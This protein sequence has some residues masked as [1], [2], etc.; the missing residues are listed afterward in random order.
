[1]SRGLHASAAND[2]RILAADPIEGICK[3]ILTQRR[4]ELVALDKTPKPEDLIKMIPEY[5][6]LIVRRYVAHLLCMVAVA[7]NCS[8][9]HCCMLLRTANHNTNRQSHVPMFYQLYE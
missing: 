7:A 2:A 1:L 4:H 5:D 8:A 9:S 6:G 3:D